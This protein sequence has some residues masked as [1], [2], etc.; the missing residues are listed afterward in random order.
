MGA[1]IQ[2]YGRRE[3]NSFM[4][5]LYSLYYT[6]TFQAAKV[7]FRNTDLD[8]T[9][10]VNTGHVGTF[11]FDL[12]DADINFIVERGY[13]STEAFFR[14]FAYKKTHLVTGR[15]DRTGRGQPRGP[16]D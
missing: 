4:D 2:G 9:I 7:F 10:G 15:E 8:R 1:R 16:M 6:V 12:E 3:V 11:D 13:N 14:H 5:Y